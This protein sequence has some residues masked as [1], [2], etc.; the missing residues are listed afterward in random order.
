VRVQRPATAARP[1][2]QGPS[3][4]AVVLA[5]GASIAAPSSAQA[6]FPQR[7]LTLVVPFAPGGIADL[8]ARAVGEHMA[9]SL[10]HAVVVENKP[11]AGAI[12]AT[13]AVA[14]ARPDGHTWLLLSNANAVSPGLFRKLPFDIERDVDP[15][16]TIGFFD[17][18]IFVRLHEGSPRFASLRELLDAARARPGRLSVATIAPG[19]TQHLAAKLFET[20]AGIDWLVVPYNGS[21][22]VLTALRAGEVDAAF[23]IAGPM[24]PHLAAAAVKALAVT[25]ERRNP[26]LPEVPTVQ[27]AGLAGYQVASWNALAVPAG[28]PP[29]LVQRLQAA[30]AD[31]LA[32]PEVRS[33]LIRLGV[34]PQPGSAAEA[35]ALLASEIRRWGAVIRA[36]RIEP[37][38]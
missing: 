3:R 10:G 6:G 14:R 22:A 36:A 35:R 5:A 11:G 29:A 38:G 17:L 28:T 33:R 31:A 16:G 12:V 21:P 4:R 9:A 20:T 27:E 25:S 18:G 7:A 24:L 1:V 30:L 37:E 19:S 13:Q 26:A 32:A 15:V 8:S 2:A 34:R 23:E